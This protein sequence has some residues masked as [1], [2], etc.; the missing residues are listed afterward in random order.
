MEVPSRF[1]RAGTEHCGFK[2]QDWFVDEK[3]KWGRVW[4]GPFSWAELFAFLFQMPGIF[5]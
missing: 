2:V 5:F 1:S 4:K 3:A